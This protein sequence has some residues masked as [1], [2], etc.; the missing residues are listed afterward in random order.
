MRTQIVV[1]L[2]ALGVL[3]GWMA[4]LGGTPANLKAQEKAAEKTPKG[5]SPVLPVP[6]APFEGLI[7]RKASESKSAFPAGVAAPKGAP[8]ILLIMTD[9]TGFGATSTFGGP[10]QTPN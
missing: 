6:D 2:L 4:G 1:A 9:D 8:N 7:G 10:I 3:L 5:G